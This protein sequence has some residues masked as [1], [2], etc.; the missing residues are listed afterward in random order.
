[1]MSRQ[2]SQ[3]SLQQRVSNILHGNPAAHAPEE[4]EHE[5]VEAISSLLEKAEEELKT[6]QQRVD[7]LSWQLEKARS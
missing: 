6:A 4:P 5:P 2:E 1:M 7:R 3:E